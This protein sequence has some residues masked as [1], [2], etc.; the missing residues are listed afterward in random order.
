MDELNAMP[1]DCQRRARGARLAAALLGIAL[2][3]LLAGC[4][5]PSVLSESQDKV[6]IAHGYPAPL[7]DIGALAAER[8]AHYGRAPAFESDAAYDG[9][10]AITSFRCVPLR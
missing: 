7:K 5:G 10:T 1:N 4:T 3:F 2:P 6:Q 9:Q 8:C